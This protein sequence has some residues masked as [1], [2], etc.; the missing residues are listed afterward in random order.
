MGDSL[1]QEGAIITEINPKKKASKKS[2]KVTKKVEKEVETL[3]SCL[4]NKTVNVKP[5][6]REKR[7]LTKDHVLYGGMAE[8]SYVVFT[9]PLV[10]GGNG[11]LMQV[12]TEEEEVFLEKE[13][14]LEEGALSIYKM[15]NNFWENRTVRLTKGDNFFHLN[16]PIDYINFKI[17]LANKDYIC[18]SEEEFE[19]T[20]KETYKFVVTTKEKSKSK[21]EE[22]VNAEIEAYAELGK[23]TGEPHKMRTVLEIIERKPLS[24]TT[25]TTTL[26]SM[27]VNV[28]KTKPNVFLNVVGDDLLDNRVL[29]NLC[30]MEG[31]IYKRGDYYYFKEDNT[32]LCL[33][34]ESPTIVTAS[35]FLD[36]P[37]NNETKLELE[38][39]VKNK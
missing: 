17:L 6:L 24:S 38:S 4:T 8:G 11:A 25:D 21:I 13:M 2:K 37:Q 14:G 33:P 27:L 39:R 34:G 36:L 12:L 3:K 31:S 10:S 19:L 29:I 23:I 7:N 35:K 18:P 20:P 26:K 22:K 30:L 32:P 16:N 15:E 5:I 28:I 9:V 1:I